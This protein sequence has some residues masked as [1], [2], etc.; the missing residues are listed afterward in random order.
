MQTGTS[1]VLWILSMLA[2]LG[3][4]ALVAWSLFRLSLLD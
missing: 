3:I 2:A 1:M 4:M